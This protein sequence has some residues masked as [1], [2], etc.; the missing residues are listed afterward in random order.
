MKRGA[1]IVLGLVLLL[2]LPF[3]N[4]NWLGD[5]NLTLYVMIAIIAWQFIPFHTLLYAVGRRQ[6]PAVLYE[7]A[8][9]DGAS[10]WQ[11]FRRVTLPQLRYTMVTSGILMVVGALTYFPAFALGPLLEHLQMV[12]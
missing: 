6:I 7:A 2:R 5:P 8:L 10:P 12:R 4:Q 9:I 11:L 1:W 3:L